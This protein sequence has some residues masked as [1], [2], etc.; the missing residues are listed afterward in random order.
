M[1]AYVML[2]AAA[3]LISV[4]VIFWASGGYEPA[5]PCHRTSVTPKLSHFNLLKLPHVP[6]YHLTRM[7][8]KD[9]TWMSWSGKGLNSGVRVFVARR[10]KHFFTETAMKNVDVNT[11]W[12]VKGFKRT[13]E[14]NKRFYV[15]RKIKNKEITMIYFL[16]TKTFTFFLSQN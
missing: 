9:D 2:R 16:V 1:L 6:I 8:W 13:T 4:S 7:E 5:N 3:A 11:N 12:N 10:A 14:T 15:S